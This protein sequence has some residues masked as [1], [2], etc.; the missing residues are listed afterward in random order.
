MV[1]FGI[2]WAKS[3]D[4]FRFIWYSIRK[5]FQQTHKSSLLMQRVRFQKNK[6]NVVEINITFT[7]DSSEGNTYCITCLC[8]CDNSAFPLD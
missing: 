6:K 5:E 2:L 8:G 1:F 7:K 3:F 4:F